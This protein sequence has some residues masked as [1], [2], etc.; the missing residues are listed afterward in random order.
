LAAAADPAAA[1]AQAEAAARAAEQAQER[2]L[3]ATRAAALAQRA[4]EQTEQALARARS[5]MAAQ[6][7]A[8]AQSAPLIRVAE[9]AAAGPANLRGVDLPTYVLARRFEEVVAAANERLGPMSAGRYQLQRSD[10]KEGARERRTGLALQIR[11][12]LAGEARSPRTLSGGETFYVSL[13]LALGLAD[14]VTAEAGGTSLETLFVDE[15]F[16]SLDNEALEAVLAQ[17]ARL[18][19]GGRVVGLVSHVETLKLAI[20]ERVEVRPA[21]EGGSTLRVR[22]GPES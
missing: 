11:D 22:A 4:A 20:P 10:A 21:P 3:A 1:A 9:L 6:A 17:L 12:N 16:G 19:A 15:G 8:R 14:V 5:A 2:E 7:Q 13:A 18:R